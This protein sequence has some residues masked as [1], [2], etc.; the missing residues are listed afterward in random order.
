MP[1][2]PD[3]RAGPLLEEEIQY[4]DRTVDGAPT[5]TGAVRRIGNSMVMQTSTGLRV[6]SSNA[7]VCVGADL[8]CVGNDVV[9]V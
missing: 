3:R 7:A 9:V 6:M 4:E 8:V 2:T 5:V 1:T